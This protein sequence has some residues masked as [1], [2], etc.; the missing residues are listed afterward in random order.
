M[1]AIMYTEEGCH[2]TVPSGSVSSDPLDD[3]PPWISSR[4]AR[5][6][7]RHARDESSPVRCSVESVGR[8]LEAFRKLCEVLEPLID[9]ARF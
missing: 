1:H 4:V 5:A 9:S 3:F 8:W 6:V 2:N 7:D